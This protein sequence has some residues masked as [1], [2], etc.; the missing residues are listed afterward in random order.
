MTVYCIWF[1]MV[2]SFIGDVFGPRELLSAI[3]LSMGEKKTARTT[4]AHG[5]GGKVRHSF[6]Y[7]HPRRLLLLNFLESR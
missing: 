7:S 4:V 1:R 3:L 6:K 5:L 2:Q